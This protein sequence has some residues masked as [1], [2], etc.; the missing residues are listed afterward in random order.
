MSA[1]PAR[2][3]TRISP[4]RAALAL[5]LLLGLQPVTTDIYLPALPLLTRDLGAPLAVAQQT[6]AALILA[7]GLGQMVW[8]P[9]TDRL[10]RRPVLLLGL[11][12]YTVAALGCSLAGSIESLVAWR[13]L[14]GAAL[15]S[16]VVVARAMLRDLYEP[17]EGAHVMSLGLSGL[18]LIALTGPALGGV[19]A[20]TLGWRAALAATALS[21]LVALVFVWRGLPETLAVRNPKAT[22][23]RPMFS[24]WADIARHP[25]F[26]AWALLT[27]CTYGGL[28]TLLAGSSFVYMDVLGLG[29]VAYG[30]ALASNSACYILGTFA[31]RRWIA[32]WGVAGAVQRAAVFTLAGGVTV[33]ALTAAGLQ[34]VWALMVPMWAYAFAHG[35]H[36][37]CGQSAVVGPFPA[38]AGAA[39]ALAGL[40]LSAIAFG[41]GAWLGVA[42]DGRIAPYAWTL[43]FWAVLTAAVAWGLVGRL[44]KPVP[45]EPAARPS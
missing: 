6:M 37:P 21:G 41:V 24:A 30:V 19:L 44:P 23:W 32:R 14:Q 40:V 36:Q 38:Q 11:A 43:G 33:V 22:Q 42:L 2:H 7:F 15:A 25:T 27:G 12:L 45:L 4:A 20:A 28:F 18:G 1:S 9:V 5:A 26:R 35:I 16:A 10:G 13:V 34:T 29:P 31:C 39:S 17:H 3:G 8:G